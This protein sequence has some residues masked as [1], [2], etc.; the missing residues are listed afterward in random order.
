MINRLVR[1]G[2]LVASV[3]AMSAAATVPT[4]AAPQQQSGCTPTGTFQDD[5]PSGYS[6]D[7]DFVY[8]SG[9]VHAN[10]FPSA[11]NGTVS[12]TNASVIYPSPYPIGATV[13]F[14]MNCRSSFDFYYTKAFNRGVAAVSVRYGN[15]AA[16]IV[17]NVDQYSSTTQWKSRTRIYLPSSA[18]VT[19]YITNLSGSEGAYIDLD[20]I[21]PR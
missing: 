19:V 8:D 1:I 9:W 6:P 16:Q 21:T 10:T 11:F 2:L 20:G 4:Q 5:N 18:P 13:S 12:Y 7:I 15:G 3:V 17:Q 14:N